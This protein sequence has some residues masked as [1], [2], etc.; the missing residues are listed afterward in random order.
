MLASGLDRANSKCGADGRKVAGNW[1]PLCWTLIQKCCT[2]GVEW[3]DLP[4]SFSGFLPIERRVGFVC[5]PSGYRFVDDRRSARVWRFL[6]LS[7]S[8]TVPC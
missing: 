5:H 7:C 1:I 4:G 3:M 6:V 2:S 8:G